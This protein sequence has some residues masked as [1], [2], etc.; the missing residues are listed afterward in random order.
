MNYLG[1]DKMKQEL[2]STKQRIGEGFYNEIKEIIKER[3][4][5]GANNGEKE[6]LRLITDQ[7]I[8]HELWETIREDT[9]D[10]QFKKYRRII[11]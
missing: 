5:T 6:S 9:L 3:K 10:Y 11:K 7:I 8:K 1:L 2:K 4:R